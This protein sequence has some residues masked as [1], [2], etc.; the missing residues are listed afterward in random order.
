[1]RLRTVI[2]SMVVA[3]V[4]LVLCVVA[5]VVDNRRRCDRGER[6]E[7]GRFWPICVADDTYMPH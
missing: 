1:M 6:P 3:L 5:L 7:E 2:L 4:L